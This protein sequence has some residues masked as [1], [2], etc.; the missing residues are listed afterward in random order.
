MVLE[1]KKSDLMCSRFKSIEMVKRPAK[2]I[3]R[4]SV[5]NPAAV[6]LII[7]MPSSS[8]RETTKMIP[9]PE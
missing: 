7:S 2:I 1:L 9:L 5:M 3:A 8:A 4:P 6:F